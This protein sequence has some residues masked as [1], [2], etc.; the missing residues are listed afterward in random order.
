MNGKNFTLERNNNHNFLVYGDTDSFYVSLEKIS[1][2]IYKKQ[3]LNVDSPLQDRVDALDRFSET[4]LQGIITKHYDELAKYKNS[5]Q[6]MFMKREAISTKG[7]WLAKK[8]RYLLNVI[9][10]EGVR[11]Q[12]PRMKVTGV[13]IV[14]S[15][16]P[17]FMR[18]SLHTLFQMILNSDDPYTRDSK[19]EFNAY[20]KESREIMDTLTPEELGFPRKI[21]DL[22]KYVNADGNPKKG[23]PVHSYGAIIYNNHLRDEKLNNFEMIKSK[24]TIKFIYIKS[25]NPWNTHVVSFKDRL[26]NEFVQYINWNKMIDKSFYDVVSLILKDVKLKLAFENDSSSVMSLLT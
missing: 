20:I 8:K 4:I 21:S 2:F 5:I 24:E 9:D 22:D 1:P 6:K 15:S 7:M 23:T 12:E 17:Q 16:I 14:K 11:Y 10:M 18:D 13:E 26:P 19:R 3:G 25:P